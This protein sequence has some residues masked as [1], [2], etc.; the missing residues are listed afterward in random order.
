[1]LG[2]RVYVYIYIYAYSILI[3]C[4][5]RFLCLQLPLS[6]CVKVLFSRITYM[7]VIDLKFNM[8]V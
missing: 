3:L 5:C 6:P 1:M 4:I 8:Y 2:I 7:C